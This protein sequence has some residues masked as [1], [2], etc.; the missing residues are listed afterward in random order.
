MNYN[1]PKCHRALYN[2]RLTH[3]G[4][5][6]AAI[7]DELR[8]TSE[9]IAKLDREMGDLEEQRRQRQLAA[10]KKEAAARQRQAN[11][12]AGPLMGLPWK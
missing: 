7:P 4:F 6:G 8:F 3:C 5:C 10:D 11:N 9:E 1:C 2:R 12:P